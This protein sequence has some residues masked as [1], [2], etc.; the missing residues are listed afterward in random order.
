M[1]AEPA[2]TNVTWSERQKL[3][4]AIVNKRAEMGILFGGKVARGQEV[5]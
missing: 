1:P 4:P 2:K 5:M 3:M